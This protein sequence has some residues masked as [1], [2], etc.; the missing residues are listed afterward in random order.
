VWETLQR[1]NSGTTETTGSSTGNKS[2]RGN[3]SRRQGVAFKANNSEVKAVSTLG[4][5]PVLRGR[6]STESDESVHNLTFDPEFNFTNEVKHSM[7]NSRSG[8]VNSAPDNKATPNP[9]PF[10]RKE[11]TKLWN[12]DYSGLLNRPAN[13]KNLASAWRIEEWSNNSYRL[14]RGFSYEEL[15]YLPDREVI[16]NKSN[17]EVISELPETFVIEEFNSMI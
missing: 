7:L 10:K 2:T 9:G 12:I 6:L 11:S 8:I 5:S 15:E 13:C 16:I 1:Q 3:S 14:A 4:E 17:L